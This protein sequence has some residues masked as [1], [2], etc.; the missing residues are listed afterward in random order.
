MNETAERELLQA[1]IEARQAADEMHRWCCEE[2]GRHLNEAALRFW[3]RVLENVL[4]V[5][6]PEYHPKRVADRHSPMTDDESRIWER[7]ETVPFGIHKGE[8]VREVPLESL[9]WLEE[10]PDFRR[11]LRRYLRSPRIQRQQEGVSNE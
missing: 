4:A 10:Q 1:K 8:F 9:V 5:L 11:E 2:A 3:Q 7:R 6:P